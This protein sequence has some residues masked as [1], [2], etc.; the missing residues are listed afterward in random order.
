MKWHVIAQVGADDFEPVIVQGEPHFTA[1]IDKPGSEHT[2]TQQLLVGFLRKGSARQKRPSIWCISLPWSIPPTSGF[3]AT[4]ERKAARVRLRCISLS[5][6]R[7]SGTL[8]QQHLPNC[9][10]S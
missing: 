2:M 3:H 6:I 9:C 7:S 5:Q 1:T 8:Q 10:H 4:I